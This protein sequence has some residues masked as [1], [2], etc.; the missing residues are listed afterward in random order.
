MEIIVGRPRGFFF[1]DAKFL[2][3]HAKKS[4]MI[5]RSGATDFVKTSLKS[6]PSSQLFGRLKV[7]PKKI[8]FWQKFRVSKNLG[9]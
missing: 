5:I 7:G 4:K 6:E 9:F 2:F 8:E 3:A 1:V